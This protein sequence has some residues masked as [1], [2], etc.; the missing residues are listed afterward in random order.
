MS[1]AFIFGTAAMLVIVEYARKDAV[2][3]EKAAVNRSKKAEEY[4]AINSRFEVML[5]RIDALERKQVRWCVCR[6]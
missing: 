1:E 4:Q 5:G 3:V 2:A 6:V